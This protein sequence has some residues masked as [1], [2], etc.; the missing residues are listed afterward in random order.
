MNFELN[1]S[2]LLLQATVRQFARNEVAPRV[3]EFWREKKVPYDLIAK[4]GQLGLMGLTVPEKYGGSGAGTVCYAIALEEM[5]VV[6]HVLGS[7]IQP[8]ALVTT[9]LVDY[10]NEEQKQQWAVPVAQGKMV[11]SFALTEPGGGSDAFGAMTT[12]AVLENG[13]WIING[14]KA[15]ITNSG[16]DICGFS[17]VCAIT[18]QQE[19]G[20]KEFSSII[21][22]RDVPGYVVGRRLSKLGAPAGDC[23]EIYLENCRVPQENL[24]GKQGKGAAQFLVALELGRIGI[25]ASSVGMARGCYELAL[26]YA[27]ERVA[28]GKPIFEHQ[29]VQFRLVDMA[30]NIEVARLVTYKAAQLRDDGKPFAKEASMAKLFASEAALKSAEDV[31]RIFAGYSFDIETQ[32][33]RFY[34]DAVVLV[35]GEGTSDIQ[36]MVIARHLAKEAV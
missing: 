34:R 14:C 25:A 9:L 12:T 35:T 1:E 32:A 19:S 22:P 21:V 30:M 28:F 7:M 36:R 18:G 20:K 5:N 8:L 13:E 10:G 31:M 4:A 26:K 11:G 3:S 16:I 27:R 29:A 17:V 2:Q 23:G 15:F 6:D 33:S 24:L